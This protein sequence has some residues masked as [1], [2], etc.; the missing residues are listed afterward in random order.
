MDH[1]R[2]EDGAGHRLLGLRRRRRR[3]RARSLGGCLA[4]PDAVGSGEDSCHGTAGIG[5]T[6]GADTLDPAVTT[7]T[8]SDP[9]AP[10]SEPTRTWFREAFAEP[11]RAQELGLAR[12]QRQQPRPDPRADR[13]RQ[14]PGRI[15]VVPRPVDDGAAGDAEDGPRALRQPAQGPRLRRRAQP[16]RPA[17][18]HSAHRRS[19]GPDRARD[20]RRVADRGHARRR[21]P[22]ADE[23][24]ARHPG[25]DARVALPAPHQPGARD[26]ARGRARDRR[27]GARH[28]RHEA[29][30]APRP[31]PRAPQPPSRCGPA[32]HRPFGHPAAARGH[33]RVPRRSGP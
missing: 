4:R 27:R 32:A 3:R 28:R 26:P 14:D 7:A 13:E 29:R 17:G 11:T 23:D 1:L 2:D 8:R 31:Q 6:L 19:A 25:H 18:R 9:L 10:F 24:P 15:P 33:R 20:Q 30:L 22:A 16:A 5:W 21:A 12:H